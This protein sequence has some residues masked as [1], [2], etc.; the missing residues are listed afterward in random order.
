MG[1]PLDPATLARAG[2]FEGLDAGALETVA[3]TSRPTRVEAGADFFVQGDVAEAFYVLLTGQVKIV[4]LSPEGHQVVIRYIGAGDVFGAVPL[5]CNTGYPGTAVAVVDS[6]AA[7]WDRA[8]TD[9]LMAAHP[10]ITANALAIVGARLQE[11]QQ[12]YRE[13]ATERVERRVAHA[14]LRLVQQAGKRVEGGVR[15]EFPISR[16]DIGEMTGTTLHTVSRILSAWEQAG[17]L[18]SGRQRIVIRKPHAIVAIAEDLAPSGP[19]S[20]E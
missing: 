15:I 7:R 12:R 1:T 19:P 14:L 10:R 4:Q 2:L 13:I 6:L 8:A 9:R 5:F 16:Q 18:E 11:L 3:R 17:L 20:E